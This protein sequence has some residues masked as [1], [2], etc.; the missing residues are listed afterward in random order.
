MSP[1]P[2]STDYLRPPLGEFLDSVAAAES[3]PG[4]GSVAA[5]SVA[6]AAAL[7]GMAA[8][9][10]TNHLPEASELADR[11]DE[12]RRLAASLAQ[13]DAEAYGR[14]LAAGRAGDT[15]LAHAL[16]EAADVPL[17]VAETGVEAAELAARLAQSGNPNLEGDA[18]AAALLAGAAAR[19]AANLVRINLEHANIQDDRLQRA[20]DLARAATDAERAAGNER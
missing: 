9:F 5:V 15:T 8:R 14:V 4:G 10:S 13:S 16:S 17:A 18:V 7:A 12:L 6:L 3:T 1:K 19:A 20:G 2:E 11:A